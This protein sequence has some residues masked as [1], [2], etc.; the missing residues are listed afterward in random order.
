[1]DALTHEVACQADISF[2]SA[3]AEEWTKAAAVDS[4]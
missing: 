4:T 3:A 2:C 1:M